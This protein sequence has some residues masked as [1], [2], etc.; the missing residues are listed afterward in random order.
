MGVDSVTPLQTARAD[1][2]GCFAD[3]VLEGFNGTIFAYGQTGSGKTYTM[4]GTDDAPGVMPQ[5]F[6]YL[7]DR[8]ATGSE[9]R[10]TQFVVTASYLEIIHNRVRDLLP[11]GEPSFLKV[12]MGSDSV[13]VVVRTRLL[14]RVCLRAHAR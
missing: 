11:E 13:R 7:F 14:C 6:R 5:A 1:R 2:R 12:S 3:A 4:Q 9:Y 10:D 8:M